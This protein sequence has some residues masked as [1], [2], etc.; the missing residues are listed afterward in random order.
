MHI[1]QRLLLLCGQSL[2]LGILLGF[3]IVGSNA[4]FLPIFGSR[5]I[6]YVYLV[7]ALFGS[8][9][10]Y[11]MAQLQQRFSLIIISVS[12]LLLTMLAFFAIWLGL[13]GPALNPTAFAYMVSFSVVIQLGFV[14]L[15]GQA[16]RLFNVQE[17][18]RNF[19]RIVA[20]F[21]VGFLLS[22]VFSPWI[23]EVRNR[24]ADLALGS[25]I[26]T[27]IMLGCLLL[28]ISRYRSDLTLAKEGS[29]Q[30]RT[31]TPPIRKL[32]L[33]PYILFLVLY[34]FL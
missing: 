23:V 16:G 10:F 19:P 24:P 7:V 6:A 21:V 4:I 27:G 11:G 29:G 22:G 17:I 28:L 3:V 15:G 2:S 32:L 9:L 1:D 20:G 13:M 8:I 25:A 34:Q 30:A 31:A 33:R 14:V 18:K 12:T 5:A 26:A